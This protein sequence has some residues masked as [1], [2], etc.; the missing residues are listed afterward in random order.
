MRLSLV[1]MQQL[2]DIQLVMRQ[3]V[4][5]GDASG[6]APL[7]IGGGDAGKRLDIHRRHFETSL[8]AALLA[9]RPQCRVDDERFTWIG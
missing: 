3:A 8:V 7:L 4:V 9:K 6:I 2:A 5:A 1:F